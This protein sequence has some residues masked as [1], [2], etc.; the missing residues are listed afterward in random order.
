VLITCFNRKDI[1]LNCLKKLTKQINIQDIEMI[2]YVVDDNSCDGT[3]R[4]IKDSYPE[5]ILLNGCGNLFWN[6]GMRMAY[7]KAK[8]KRFDYYLWLN[9]D[10]Q[11]SSHAISTLFDCAKNYNST[12]GNQAIIIG[13]TSDTI[14][15]KTTYGGLVRKSNW[16]KTKFN[17]VPATTQPQLC[18][19]MN[20]NCVLIPSVIA[21]ALGNMERKFSHGMGDIDYG[22]R[23]RKLGYDILIAPNYVGH[24]ERNNIKGSFEDSSLP[25]KKRIQLILS[26][27]GLPLKTWIIFT[28]R[29]AGV[30]WPIYFIWPY[31]SVLLNTLSEAILKGLQR[32][33]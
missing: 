31:V 10:T 13:S 16:Q 3:Y 2:I 20:G 15:S 29:H 30:F 11:L 33:K 17:V 5:V 14:K 18:D 7:D 24:C 25:L 21:N 32:Y 27:K 28:R 8:L 22:L 19:T 23:A 4:A 12:Y 6:G 26:P 1:T 9:D